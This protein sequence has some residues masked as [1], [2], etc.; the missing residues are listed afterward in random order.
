MG[1]NPL[2]TLIA[3]FAGLKIFGFW[4]LFIFPVALIVIIKYYKDEMELEKVSLN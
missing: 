2:F 1:I 3:M 4:G